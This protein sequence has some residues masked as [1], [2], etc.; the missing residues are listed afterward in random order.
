MRRR[1]PFE[2]LKYSLQKEVPPMPIYRH[3]LQNRRLWVKVLVPLPE[4]TDSICCRF[5]LRGKGLEK[6]DASVRGTAP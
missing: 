6:L 2:L 1:F 3:H 5:F 4:K